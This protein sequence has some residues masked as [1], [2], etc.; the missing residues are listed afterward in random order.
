MKLGLV[1]YNLA[2]DW[3]ADT[4]I[5]YCRETG[6]EGVEPRTTHAHGIEP[7]LGKSQR[8]EVKKKFEGAGIELCGRSEERRVGKEG[9]SRWSPY[10]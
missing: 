6:F 1:T 5:G 7:S 3:D 4:L 10:Y 8:F 2:K 9:R